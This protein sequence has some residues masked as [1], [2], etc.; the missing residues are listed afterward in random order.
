VLY[1][2]F[3]LILQM[4]ALYGG[5]VSLV[6]SNNWVITGALSNDLAMFVNRPDQGFVFGTSNPSSMLM[7]ITSNGNVG[8]GMSNPGAQL[9]VAC[10]AR[11]DGSLQMGAYV[12]MGGLDL[13][14]GTGL[15]NTAQVILSTSNIQGY[16]NLL[17]S[18][19]SNG[20]LFSIMSNSSN[21]A[22]YWMSG[23]SS[24][25]IAKLTG[26]GK[27]CIGNSNP[28]AMLHVVNNTVTS[29]AVDSIIASSVGSGDPNFNLCALKGGQSNAGCVAQLGL[30]YGTTSNGINSA[31]QFYRGPTGAGGAMAFTTSNNIERVRIDNAGNV[32][33]GVTAPLA[34]LHVQGDI[35]TSTSNAFIGTILETGAHS[36]TNIGDVR[37]GRQ[38]YGGSVGFY[39]F[40]G[41]ACRVTNDAAQNPN[42]NVNHAHI[43]FYTWGNNIS[44]S[45]E[46]MRIRSDG[47][48]GIGT[49]MPAYKFDVN[50]SA[51][52]TGALS[53][54]SGSFLI[55]H[56]IDRNMELVHS[57]IEG[58]RA[59]L[60]YRG[61]KVLVGGKAIVDL[62][63][64]CTGNGST[65]MKGTF[66]ALC[67]DPQVY[68]QNNET[69]D[70]LKGRVDNAILTIEC[71]NPEA[72]YEV[73]WM[74]VAERKDKTVIDWDMTDSNGQLIL[75]R[76][77]QNC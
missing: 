41:M 45:V 35:R 33:I 34:A 65:M 66:E 5:A 30:V 55:P 22:F 77:V 18:G 37:I 25:Q 19:G 24:N 14:L 48:V 3:V 23:P 39:E 72:S 15:S 6:S 75:E 64:E 70:R 50:G 47:N 13:F 32:G 38:D 74:V 26:E 46:R 2:F 16:S 29:H 67:R 69:W 10:N 12:Q 68:L 63:R 1:I 8:I 53:K 36:T 9:H 21:D 51:R 54:G 76:K 52:I 7:R 73:D 49:T 11:I 42:V 28:S 40:S 61:K 60:I 59:D 71:E 17:W 20:T 4:A 62:N 44:G 27:L 31:I 58:P 57:F 43:M 56:P